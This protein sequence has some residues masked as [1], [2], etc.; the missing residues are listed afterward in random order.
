MSELVYILGMSGG[1]KSSS[2]GKSKR[3]GIEGLNPLNTAIINCDGKRLLFDNAKEWNFE[4]TNLVITKNLSIIRNSLIKIKDKRTDIKNIVIDDFQY[5]ITDFFARGI[6]DK[7]GLGLYTDIF[8]EVL[9]TFDQCI[10]MRNDQIV[11]ITNHLEEKVE[12]GITRKRFKAVG[13]ALH[14]HITPEGKSNVVLYA[15]GELVEGNLS[16]FFRTR[17]D[18]VRDSCKTPDGMFI[19]SNGK[20]LDRIPNDLGFVEKRMREV[21]EI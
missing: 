13:D 18:G 10:N 1:G 9:D 19:D 5:A 12:N 17:G 15:E 16:K 21:W 20:N 4:K 6:R 3:L 11:F 8:G 7:V 14:K 2:I